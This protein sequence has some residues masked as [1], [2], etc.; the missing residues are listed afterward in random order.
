M[1]LD[2]RLE[3]GYKLTRE[4]VEERSRR[5][6]VYLSEAGLDELV[7][8]INMTNIFHTIISPEEIILHN[9]GIARLEQLGLLDEENLKPLLRYMLTHPSYKETQA[10]EECDV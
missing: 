8:F 9:A 5:R 2:C 3:N 6:K 7:S 10:L 4:E 1:L